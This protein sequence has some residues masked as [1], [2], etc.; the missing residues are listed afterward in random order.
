MTK[1]RPTDE[2]PSSDRKEGSR[3]VR[4]DGGEVDY[5]EAEVNLFKPSTPFMRDHMSMIKKGFAVWLVLV[6]APPIL[7]FLVPGAMST[8]IPAIGFPLHYFL[9]AFG[10]PTGT[11]LLSLWYTRKRDAL[12]EKYGIGDHATGSGG[13][14]EGAEAAADG[15]G[16]V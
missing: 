13:G 9:M 15:G 10:G 1:D 5:L 4:A 12:D 3:E 6:F 11:L 16:D 2:R 14:H 8:Q 7:T